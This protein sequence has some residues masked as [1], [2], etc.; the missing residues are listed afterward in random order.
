MS[1]VQEL[2]FVP[3]LTVCAL[4]RVPPGYT[5]SVFKFFRRVCVRSGLLNLQKNFCPS[6]LLHHVV[7]PLLVVEDGLQPD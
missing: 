5:D 7:C 1:L 3:K 6:L 4:G 2:N